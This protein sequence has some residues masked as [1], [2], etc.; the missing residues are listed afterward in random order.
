MKTI[1]LLLSVILLS[2]GCLR[3]ESSLTVQEDGSG[4]LQ[5]QYSLPD[6]AIAQMAAAFELQ[7]HLIEAAGEKVPATPSLT[8]LLANPNDATLRRAFLTAAPK[9]LTLQQLIVDQ[10]RGNRRVKIELAFTSLDALTRASFF[11][12][13]NIS[14]TKHDDGST[15]LALPAMTQ[16]TPQATTPAESEQHRA[17]SDLSGDLR[18]LI[19]ITVPGHIHETSAHRQ[20]RQT[21]SWIFDATS[22]NRALAK[23][24]NTTFMLR[25]SPKR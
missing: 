20:A 23:L 6:P 16:G 1:P 3:L 17:V 9:G 22:D 24:Q 8:R 14:L 7:D 18:A 21:V 5:I 12:H 19:R 11:Q 13:A 2:T 15:Q 4:L 10:R 25:F